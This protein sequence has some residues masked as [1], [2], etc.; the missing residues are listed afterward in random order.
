MVYAP[1]LKL[2]MP[3][4]LVDCWREPLLRAW[5]RQME[6]LQR[7]VL[8]LRAPA[9]WQLVWKGGVL[10]QYGSRK[11]VAEIV[12]AYLA[13]RNRA[14]EQE[15]PVGWDVV[16]ANPEMVIAGPPV[17][18]ESGYRIDHDLC[19][20]FIA[21][22]CLPYGL[23]DPETVA[24]S[25][26]LCSRKLCS[27]WDSKI[28]PRCARVKHKVV[29]QPCATS[30]VGLSNIVYSHGIVGCGTARIYIHTGP[31]IDP[32][33][34]AERYYVALSCLYVP[35]LGMFNELLHTAIARKLTELG[36]QQIL[37]PESGSGKP[38]EH[39]QAMRRG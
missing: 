11:V 2:W 22:G 1:P 15:P 24:R 20:I 32:E 12:K 17:R 4:K 10:I 5:F 26:Y 25:M 18:D 7:P 39:Y 31:A 38:W 14:A 34:R 37:T 33:T 9:P 13:T 6:F 8:D 28:I 23:R 16:I 21:S 36:C 27:E 29:L 30:S 19:R 35:V 3:P